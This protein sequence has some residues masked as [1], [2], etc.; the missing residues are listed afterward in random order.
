MTSHPRAIRVPPYFLTLL[1]L[2][3]A[4]PLASAQRGDP[5]RTVRRAATVDQS[6]SSK[7]EGHTQ[8]SNGHRFRAADGG[9]TVHDS[10]LSVTWL[11][12]ANVGKSECKNVPNVGRGGGMDWNTAW[13]CIGQLNSGKGS[14]GHTNWQM[15]ATPMVDP[16]CKSTGLQGNSFAEN[17]AG[18]ALGSLF[19]EAFQ[20]HFGETV[21]LQVGPT[22]G[23]FSNL[24]PTIY[25]F[26]NSLS[27]QSG[28][29]KK[30]SN[31]GYN[32]FSFSNGWQ[33]ANVNHHVMYILPVIPGPLPAGSPA[34]KATIWDPT[35]ESGVPGKT[36]ISWL[37][38]ANVASDPG[39]LQ[40]VKA[41]SLHIRKD[42]SMEQ[43]TAQ[44]LVKLMQQNKY[45]GRDDWALPLSS[46]TNCTVNGKTGTND[47]YDCTVSTMGH[48]Y[49]EVF[50]LKPGDAVAEPPDIP[51]VQPFLNVQP[52]LYWACTAANPNP[53]I[54]TG[55][56]LCSPAATAA[57]GMGFSFDMGSGFTDTTVGASELSLMVYYPDPPSK[58]KCS[59]PIQCCAQA[60]GILSGG[61]CR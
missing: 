34:A 10:L 35:A 43:G 9:R 36:G 7:T 48:L 4:V 3:T 39:F 50:K 11:L 5:N 46:S 30:N 33:G 26:G 17:C 60:G 19:Y 25:W 49:Y 16:S 13:A 23:G 15:P 61:K 55:A 18:S 8:T 27:Q 29:K 2:L 52:T 22:K 54:G 31:N 20:R 51:E 45:L 41:G 21:A 59:T 28:G 58:P 14:L 53:I 44:Q 42:G 6:T 38:D 37:A 24:Q 40:T 57:S 56:N 32:S 12:D 1:L 47:G